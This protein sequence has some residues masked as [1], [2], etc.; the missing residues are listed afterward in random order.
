MDYTTRAA[1]FL[2]GVTAH[3]G[4]E[5][6]TGHLLDLLDLAPESTVI[7]VATGAGATLRAVRRRGHRA[8]GVDLTPT[9]V[10]GD[11]HALPVRTGVADAVVIE[12][13]L[14]TFDRPADALAE[15]RRVL[16]TGGQLGL[17]DITLDR[18]AA[19]PTVSAAVDRL[20]HA[21]TPAAYEQLLVDAGFKVRTREDRGTDAAVLV[22]RLRRRLPLSSTLRA[23]EQAVA[24]GAL[25]YGLLIAT[26]VDDAPGTRRRG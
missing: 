20:T 14:S 8:I 12:C 7:D 15:A 21:R 13:S 9:D 19:G 24:S 22:R 2:L 18:A 26:A 6:L 1:R 25:S 23:C 11:A 5:A 10:V 4:G 16:R 17:T 3:P